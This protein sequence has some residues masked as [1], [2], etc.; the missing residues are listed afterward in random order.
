VIIS[1]NLNREESFVLL[2]IVNMWQGTVRTLLRLYHCDRWDA[3]RFHRSVQWRLPAFPTENTDP[4][5]SISSTCSYAVYYSSVIVL[6][7]ELFRPRLE[8][9]P[10]YAFLFNTVLYWLTRTLDGL[11]FAAVI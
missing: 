5:V 8:D 6:I 3:Q 7:D 4:T 11:E 2:A 1:L 10:R 9:N